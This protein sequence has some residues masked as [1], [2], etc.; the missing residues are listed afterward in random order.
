MA[1]FF[2]LLVFYQQPPLQDSLTR[3]ASQD[4]SKGWDSIFK[5]CCKIYDKVREVGF[6]LFVN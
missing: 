2:L 5:I 4:L 6:W 1:L 3:K